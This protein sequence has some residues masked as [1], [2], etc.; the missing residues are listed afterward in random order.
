MSDDR[1]LANPLL[2]PSVAAFATVAKTTGQPLRLVVSTGVSLEV[3]ISHIGRDYLAGS[4]G[5]AEDAMAI[6]PTSSIVALDAHDL[7]DWV[8]H[9]VVSPPARAHLRAMLANSQRLLHRVSV[10][11]AV[12]HH[13]GL[14]DRVGID[15]VVV[16]TSPTSHR[17]VL[18]HHIIWIAVLSN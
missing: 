16:A 1:T 15:A 17:L 12:G 3:R 4:L 6:I 18:I 13:S 9:D 2:H 11:T 7:L 5:D 10:Y 14:I 8:G